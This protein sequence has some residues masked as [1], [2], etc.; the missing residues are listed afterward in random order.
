MNVSRR[1]FLG[2]A[3][4]MAAAGCATKVPLARFVAPGE[5][6]A[7]LLHLGHNMWCDWIPDDMDAAAV[8]AGYETGR[9]PALDT[10]LRSKDDLWRKA[11]FI[12]FN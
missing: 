11:F 1:T 12:L 10:A 5:I 6:K 9:S 8:T 3:A 2:G 4:A 7:L